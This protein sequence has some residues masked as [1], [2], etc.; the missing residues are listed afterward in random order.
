MEWSKYIVAS[1]SR[2][3]LVFSKIMRTINCDNTEV[4]LK[5]IGNEIKILLALN[6]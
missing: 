6:V 5:R 4:E 3:S 2:L 1:K